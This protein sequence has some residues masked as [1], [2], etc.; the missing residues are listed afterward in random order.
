MFLPAP[1]SSNGTPPTDILRASAHKP[2]SA[3]GLKAA[4]PPPNRA[5]PHH[6]Q[7]W[8]LPSRP[9]GPQK[10]YHQHR[11]QNPPGVLSDLMLWCFLSCLRRCPWSRRWPRRSCSF[12]HRSCFCVVSVPHGFSESRT[13]KHI[14]GMHTV[15][16]HCRLR[17][18]L[19]SRH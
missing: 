4:S 6:L 16:G 9:C 3:Q 17:P 15:L 1:K 5:H 13:R 7:S 12:V 19:Y 8:L 2:P 14:I 10:S 18:G 11:H